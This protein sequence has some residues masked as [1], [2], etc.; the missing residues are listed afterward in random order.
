MLLRLA[1]AEPLLGLNSKH[2]KGPKPITA[3][4]TVIPHVLAGRNQERLKVIIF[5]V[6]SNSTSTAV[7][8]WGLSRPLGV[9]RV[10]FCN[11]EL[12]S[13]QKAPRL[14]SEAL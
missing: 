13:K 1:E 8:G 5:G 4:K 10:P 14:E 7:G 2:K 9:E 11:A 12:P 3:K 6:P